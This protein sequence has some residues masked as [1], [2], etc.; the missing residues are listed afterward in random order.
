MFPW[1]V[2]LKWSDYAYLFRILHL[3][4]RILWLLNGKVEELQHN[5]NWI[6]NMGPRENLTKQYFVTN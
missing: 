2:Q 4:T 1:I 6:E 5:Y 3:A